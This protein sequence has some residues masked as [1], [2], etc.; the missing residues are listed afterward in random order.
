MIEETIFSPQLVD[1]LDAKL[2]EKKQKVVQVSCG[3]AH[4]VVLTDKGEVW[5]WGMSLYGQ[6]GIGISGDSFEP[7]LGMTLSKKPEPTNITEFLPQDTVV[8]KIICGAA[9]TLFLTADNELYGCGINDL[10]QLGLDTYL[11]EM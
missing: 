11:E 3:E 2:K 9:F 10:G 7:G 5:G 8:S 4:S 6:L 1:K